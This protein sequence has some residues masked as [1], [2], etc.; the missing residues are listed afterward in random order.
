MATFKSSARAAFTTVATTLDAATKTINV[1]SMA[2]DMAHAF[3]EAELQDQRIGYK[4]NQG[5]RTA[6]QVINAKQAIADLQLR[7][8]AFI[9]KSPDHAAAYASAATYVD[10]IVNDLG[11]QNMPTI[12]VNQS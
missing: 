6:E 3:M 11:I 2:V 9:Q 4:L 8:A 5:T 12:T 10:S 1:A 7:A